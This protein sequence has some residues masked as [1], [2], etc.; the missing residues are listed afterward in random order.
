V[1]ESRAI[2]NALS[3]DIEDWFHLV[4]IEAVADPAT[5]AGFPTLVVD[6]TRFI[7]KALDEHS[8]RATFFVLGWI[9]ERYPE[10]VREIAA[11]GH[12]VASH[13][14][15]HVPVWK[16][17]REEF[18]A[19]VQRSMDA[20]A[21]AGGGLVRGY[22]A[23]SFSIIP[24]GEWAFDVLAELG[25]SYDASLFPAPRGH[26]GH[27]CPDGP[28][29]I[30]APSGAKIAELPMSI[31][32][33][34]PARVP[35]SGGGYLRLLP[36]W[37]IRRSVGRT[38]RAGRPAVTYLHPRDFAPDGPRVPMPLHRRF[39]CYVGLGTT[40]RKLRA[41]LREYRW[42]TCAEVLGLVSPMP[43]ASIQSAPPT[44]GAPPTAGPHQPAMRGGR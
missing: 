17:S 43:A 13:G 15:M 25:L 6:R 41:L 36:L 7:L 29:T 27:P 11:A 1:A 12:E 35:Y 38:N 2:L 28:H 10:V 23:P 31:G 32:R 19:D 30:T 34:G 40:E 20:I 14:S 24:G 44:G 4:D 22:R 9:A 16:Q 21:R 3:F 42:G 5:W 37:L 8:T 33:I 26:G 18:R 39:K